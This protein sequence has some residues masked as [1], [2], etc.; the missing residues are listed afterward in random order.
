MVFLGKY[1]KA[2]QQLFSP[3]LFNFVQK[4]FGPHPL[5]GRDYSF[6]MKECKVETLKLLPFYMTD[7]LFTE[8]QSHNI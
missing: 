3:H 6:Y 8:L 5:E 4:F 1:P 7:F 2:L